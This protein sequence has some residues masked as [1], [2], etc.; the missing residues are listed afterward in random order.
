VTYTMQGLFQSA[1]PLS[2]NFSGAPN[3]IPAAIPGTAANRF[4]QGTT[5]TLPA[6]SANLWLQLQMPTGVADTGA[7]TLVLSVNGQAS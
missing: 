6:A 1:Q 2:A 4:G 3:N 5:K 7:H